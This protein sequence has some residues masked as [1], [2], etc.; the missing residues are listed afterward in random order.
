MILVCA[1]GR[2]FCLCPVF[3][4]VLVCFWFF[5]HQQL[6]DKKELPAKKPRKAAAL[7][8]SPVEEPKLG[9]EVGV[10]YRSGSC[11]RLGSGGRC[12]I[13]FEAGN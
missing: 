12:P 8:D 10:E 6:K 3:L 1:L 11:S 4:A 9:P 7:P 2:V 5:C 13:S